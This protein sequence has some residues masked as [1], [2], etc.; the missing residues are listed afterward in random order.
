MFDPCHPYVAV[1]PARQ[2]IDAVMD[3]TTPRTHQHSSTPSLSLSRAT[4]TTETPSPLSPR[5]LRASRVL[6]FAFHL[7]P[8]RLQVCL[9]LLHLLHPLV[10]RDL[11]EV[12]YM[13]RDC[14]R[15]VHGRR[16]PIPVN[17]AA[18]PSLPSFFPPSRVRVCLGLGYGP[19]HAILALVLPLRGNTANTPPRSP[20]TSTPHVSRLARAIRV[21]RFY[22]ESSALSH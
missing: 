5:A 7:A 22:L 15:R 18:A 11:P 2:V 14:R 10:G 21:R 1:G 8:E 16:D 19:C 12:S 20:P 13:S 9:K 4:P 3:A 6:V 17:L